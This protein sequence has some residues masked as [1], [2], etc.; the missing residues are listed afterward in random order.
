MMQQTR[1]YFI[2]RLAAMDANV[3]VVKLEF[4]AELKKV[5]CHYIDCTASPDDIKSIANAREAQMEHGAK[6]AKH[7]EACAPRRHHDDDDETAP[8]ILRFMTKGQAKHLMEQQ[9]KKG[10]A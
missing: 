5:G 7:V 2:D 3:Q 10:G 4:E 1:A 9:K 8:G 6:V